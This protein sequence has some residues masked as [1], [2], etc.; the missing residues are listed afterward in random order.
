MKQKKALKN[1]IKKLR[2]IDQS[3]NPEEIQTIVYSS[4]KENGYEK[5]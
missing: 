4:G 2:E 1:L 3:L 5:I